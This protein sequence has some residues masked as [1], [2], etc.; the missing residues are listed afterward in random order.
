MMIRN[1]IPSIR[2]STLQLIGSRRL[3]SGNMALIKKHFAPLNPEK[4][5]GSM[6]PQL[7]GVV[8][9]VD[10]TLWSV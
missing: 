3:L 8:F 2:I 4:A 9:D 6:A 5:K 10:G 1:P 7:K